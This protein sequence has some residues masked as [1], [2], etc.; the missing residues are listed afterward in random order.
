[1]SQTIQIPPYAPDPY[2]MGQVAPPNDLTVDPQYH[3]ARLVTPIGRLLYCHVAKPH[4]IAQPGR[5]PGDPKFTATLGFNPALSVDMYNVV[6]AVANAH[7]PSVQRAD[8]NNPGQIV[9]VR[10]ADMLG[11]DE[12]MGGF[13][14][15]IRSGDEAFAASTKPLTLAHWR[16]LYFINTSMFPKTKAGVEQRPTCL[17]ERGELTNPDRFY[18]GCYAR[19][20]VVV[21]WFSNAGNN[22]V[23]FYLEAIQFANHGEPIRMGFDQEASAKDAFA[24]AGALPP[25]QPLPGGTFGPNHATPGSVPP[26]ATVAGFA[27]PPPPAAAYPP[28]G[29]QPQVPAAHVPPQQPWT[30]AQGGI[31]RPPGV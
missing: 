27:A 6:C 31:A 1:M 18:P 24:K 16:G 22:G 21:S 25:A 15:P 13:H 2:L 29:Q 14:Y 10:G 30:P 12:K 11:V 17:D 4:A 28:Q 8:P 5:P 26:G 9:A 23:T 20:K 3:N 19:L 7:W